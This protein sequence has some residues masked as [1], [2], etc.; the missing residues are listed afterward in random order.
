MLR[1]FW[2]SGAGIAE[3]DDNL[4]LMSSAAA[5]NS[6]CVDENHGASDIE[7]NCDLKKASKLIY[8]CNSKT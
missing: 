6:D 2:N 4:R 7:S 1:L 3:C 8:D 5:W